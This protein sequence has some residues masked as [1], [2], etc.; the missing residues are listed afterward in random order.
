MNIFAFFDK[1]NVINFYKKIC[2]LLW[3]RV[4]SGM[5]PKF[6]FI[7]NIIVGALFLNMPYFLI[8]TKKEGFY[9]T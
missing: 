4:F 3:L 6:T 5:K 2:D 8:I 7:I 1:F 9:G